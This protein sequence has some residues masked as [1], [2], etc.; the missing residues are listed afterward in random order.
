MTKSGTAVTET[1]KFDSSIF[2]FSLKDIPD[3][4][5]EEE[6]R[7]CILSWE[8]LSPQRHRM[9]QEGA[10][11]PTS[12]VTFIPEPGDALFI[13]FGA[14]EPEPLGQVPSSFFCSITRTCGRCQKE[15]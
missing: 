10:K 15:N 14:V 4:C 5:P 12:V 1:L 7:C 3:R 6:F 9:S 11:F 13:Y 2:Y 8:I